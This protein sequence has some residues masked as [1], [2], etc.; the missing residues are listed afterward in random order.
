MINFNQCINENLL[1]KITIGKS[2]A[3]VY[4]LKGSR[5]AKHI[6]RCELESDSLW[7][8]YKS[9][10]LFYTHFSELAHDFLPEIYH[11]YHSDDEIQIIMRQYKILNRD[12]LDDV[13]LEKVFAVLAQIHSLPAPEFIP[14]EDTE[15]LILNQEDISKYLLGW[16][17][18]LEEHGQE[19]SKSDLKRIAQNIN[20]INKKMHST[21]RAL[22]H[23]DFHFEN[24]LEDNNGNIIVC[25]WQCIGLGHVSA[26]ISFL[27]SRLAA[28][29]FEVNKEKAIQM[30]CQ[31]S[32]S[33]ITQDEIAMQMSLANL[34][35]S[36]MFWHNYLH[37]SSVDTVRDIFGKMV[38]D[39]NNLM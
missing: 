6:L 29:G 5:I 16:E 38:E 9:E 20:D 17:E 21:K 32:K 15:P 31:Y 30:Y 35:T 25:D 18:V 1:Q 27:L 2:G 3:S 23:G 22:C 36:F 11:C 14:S 26:D 34:N 7:N 19:F 24:L 8:S 4:E 39:M 13:L 33:D 37:G 28:D 12:S 10:S